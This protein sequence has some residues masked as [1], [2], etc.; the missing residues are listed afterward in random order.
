[1]KI[2]VIGAGAIGGSLAAYLCAA[3]ADVTILELNSDTCNRIVNSGLTVIDGEKTF[4]SAVKIVNSTDEL[5]GKV[6]DCCFSATRA[7]NMPDAVKSVLPYLAGDSLIVAMNNGVCIDELAAIVGYERAV[8]GM[9]NYGVGISSPGN[10][11]IKVR[12]DLVLGM[13]SKNNSKNI[14]KPL[15]RLSELLNKVVPTSITDNITGCLYSKML[16][17]SCITSSALIS[18]LLLG[19]IL[20]DK[21]GRALFTAV[22]TEGV[23]VAKAAGITIPPYAGKLNYY[24]LVKNDLFHKIKRRLTYSVMA[25]K[26]KSRTSAALE[27]LRRGVKTETYYFNGYIARLGRKYGVPTPANDKICE[28][29]KRVENNIAFISPH[30]LNLGF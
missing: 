15:V 4:S 2:L 1:M 9:I 28:L 18:G 6:F 3:S 29:I 17:N 10:Y 8:G 12:G 11:Y 21:K 22:A 20:K 24:S 25:K 14:L 7:Y 27:A 23:A 19:S 30:N 13:I 5:K 16:I 26:Y